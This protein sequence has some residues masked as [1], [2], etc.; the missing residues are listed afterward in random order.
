MLSLLPVAMLCLDRVNNHKH[1][2][3]EVTRKMPDCKAETNRQHKSLNFRHF[4][5]TSRK[6][7]VIIVIGEIV[8]GSRLAS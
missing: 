6:K 1:D 8:L 4:K 3:D 7:I 2:R 5:V